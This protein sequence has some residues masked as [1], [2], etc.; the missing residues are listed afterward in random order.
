MKFERNGR[1]RVKVKGSAPQLLDKGSDARTGFWDGRFTQACLT[2]DNLFCAVR[3]A[4][5]FC[6]AQIPCGTFNRVVRNAAPPH[7]CPATS[8]PAVSEKGEPPVRPELIAREPPPRHERPATLSDLSAS[9]SSQHKDD[10]III[11][12]SRSRTIIMIMDEKWVEITNVGVSTCYKLYSLNS[13]SRF[14]SSYNYSRLIRS[15]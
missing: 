13:D 5:D 3:S 11:S 8:V 10:Q 15:S 14:G 9:G 1:K 2:G 7:T 6:R 4:G 12:R